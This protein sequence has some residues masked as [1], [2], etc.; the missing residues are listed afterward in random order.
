MKTNPIKLI[1][2]VFSTVLL[3]ATV[4][5]FAQGQADKHSARKTQTEAGI[6]VGCNC[7]TSYSQNEKTKKD[8]DKIIKEYKD[9]SYY[10]QLK[11]REYL[12]D[13]VHKEVSKRQIIEENINRNLMQLSMKQQEQIVS[14]GLGSGSTEAQLRVAIG[15]LL[16]NITNV[17][18]VKEITENYTVT[19]EVNGKVDGRGAQLAQ[20]KSITLEPKKADN[21]KLNGALTYSKC[22]KDK[23]LLKFGD[24][25]GCGFNQK[26]SGKFETKVIGN[27]YTG[28]DFTSVDFSSHNAEGKFFIRISF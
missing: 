17:P 7:S 4:K 19:V 6:Q 26:V 8:L 2:C 1:K 27:L 10:Q 15:E 16:A 20:V 21:N 11:V 13:M 28:G 3:I 23:A 12:N 18:A 22:D 9:P 14:M 5:S 24:A 25:G